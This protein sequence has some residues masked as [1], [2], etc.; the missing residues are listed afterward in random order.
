MK[1]KNLIEAEYTIHGQLLKTVLSAED[2]GLTIDPKMNYN[3]HISNI[4]KKANSSRSFNHRNTRSCPQKVKL[5][6]YTL[7]VRPQLKYASRVWCPHTAH[8]INRLESVQCHAARSVMN[9]WSRP[10]SQTT[11]SSRTTRGSPAIMMQQLGW[12]T[13][14]E[15]RTQARAIMMYRVVYD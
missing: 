3:E 10:H 5:A 2:L 11:P 14:E 4:S 13:L 9:D 6:T 12:S 7:F 15:C 8:S 1:W